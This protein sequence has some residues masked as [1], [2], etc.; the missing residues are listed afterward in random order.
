MK[1]QKN[2]AVFLDRDGVINEDSGYVYKIKD[3]FFKDGIFE[4]LKKLQDLDYLLFIVTNQSGI[5]RGYYKEDDF[6]KLSA[7]VK[8]EFEKKDIKIEKIYYCPHTPENNCNCRKPKNGMFEKAIKE[9]D[10]NTENSWMVGDKPSDIEAANRSGIYNTILISD[11][12]YK[13]AKYHAYNIYDIINI[14]K[15]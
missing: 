6:L 10:I 13:K 4:V 12:K 9:F 8:K 15:D 14:I 2:R 1:K 11:T 5:G 3:F 7:W